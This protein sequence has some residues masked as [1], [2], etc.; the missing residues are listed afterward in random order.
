MCLL[1]IL[2]APWGKHIVILLSLTGDWKDFLHASPLASKSL[3]LSLPTASLCFP[4]GTIVTG[5]EAA[6]RPSQA[7][8][9]WAMATVLPVGT[10][11]QGKVREANGVERG[12]LLT[13]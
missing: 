2:A 3:F 6:D 10:V 13:G 4:K 5:A 12:T 1:A 11:L 7:R 9:S 8:G